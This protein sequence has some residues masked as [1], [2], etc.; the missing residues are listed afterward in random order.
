MCDA[1]EF[2]FAGDGLIWQRSRGTSTA[3][4]AEYLATAKLLLLQKLHFFTQSTT[5][6]EVTFATANVGTEALWT[7]YWLL[8]LSCNL[9]LF[10]YLLVA[11]LICLWETKSFVILF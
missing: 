4:W 3:G 5:N 11:D 8:L 2:V 10:A 9:N 1:A 7:S 6:E